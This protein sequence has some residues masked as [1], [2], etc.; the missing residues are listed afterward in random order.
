M[1]YDSKGMIDIAQ[2]K[3][4]QLEAQ[5]WQASD[6][7]RYPILMDTSP[8]SKRSKEQFTRPLNIFEPVGFVNQ[9]LLSELE[10]T[11]KMRAY[12]YT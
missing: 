12:C 2:S 5:L 8:C 3:S 11:P 4:Q 10:I 1:P 6:Q 9:F 7:G